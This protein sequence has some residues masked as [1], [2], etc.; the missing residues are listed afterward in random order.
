MVYGQRSRE[1]V[2]TY[3]GQ[4]FLT[5]ERIHSMAWDGLAAAC[6]AICP[7]EVEKC[8][9]QAYEEGLIGPRYI[10]WKNISEALAQG[11]KA[12]MERARR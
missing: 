5:L 3:F 9:R 4:L 2:L 10:A 8:L 1:E 12:V 7:A 6:A 11:P